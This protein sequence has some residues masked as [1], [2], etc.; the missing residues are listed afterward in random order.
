MNEEDYR[1]KLETIVAEGPGKSEEQLKKLVSSFS[2]TTKLTKLLADTC[3]DRKS[4]KTVMQLLGS[5][6]HT[7]LPAEW[8]R[9]LAEAGFLEAVLRYSPVKQVAKDDPG[10]ALEVLRYICNSV[11]DVDE[12]RAIVLPCMIDLL[13]T[14]GFEELRVAALSAVLN[15]CQDY[16]PG[17]LELVHLDSKIALRFSLFLRNPK[18]QTI[19]IVFNL[20]AI[21]LPVLD[22][23]K[24]TRIDYVNLLA[25][26]IMVIMDAPGA[27][28]SQDDFIN[29]MDSFIPV[30]RNEFV[31]DI[32]SKDMSQCSNL[33]E[34]CILRLTGLKRLRVKNSPA[35]DEGEDDIEDEIVELGTYADELV[36]ILASI[37]FS[38]TFKSTT[39][40]LSNDDVQDMI[41]WLSEEWNTEGAGFTKRD[42]EHIRFARAGALVLGNIATQEWIVKDLLQTNKVVPA[43]VDA[44]M[45]TEDRELL[46]AASGLLHNLA[47]PSSSKE[48]MQKTGT[49][50]CVTKLLSSK[51]DDKPDVEVCISGL[52]LLRVLL[53]DSRAN[54]NY[55]FL[56]EDPAAQKA[57]IKLLQDKGVTDARIR[58]ETGR[59]LVAMHRSLA[60]PRLPTESAQDYDATPLYQIPEA[61]AAIVSLITHPDPRNKSQGWMGLALVSKTRNGAKAVQNGFN[62]S[63]EEL[64]TQVEEL[65]AEKDSPD[66]PMLS[67]D[68]DNALVVV[69][70]MMRN[71]VSLPAI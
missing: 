36:G 61:T 37:A 70:N 55:F 38:A 43:A 32:L 56:S 4:P 7:F 68:K 12:N 22:T 11:A 30:L 57:L 8:R 44:I 19:H 6:T 67:K 24:T 16:E 65:L 66:R 27:T 59:A 40:L 5:C 34:N 25:E 69:A 23:E 17:P 49:F 63:G 26:S 9:P 53:L 42:S 20:L 14:A 71:E 45:G 39:D 52:K 35:S 50:K 48:V 15:L 13:D 31:Q 54:V 62:T 51:K 58:T 60:G 41:R 21:V 29:C 64:T 3:R 46:N 2:P 1:A 28:S 18:R 47:I 10:L 33:M